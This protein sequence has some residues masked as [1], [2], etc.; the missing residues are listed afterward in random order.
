MKK[1]TKRKDTYCS[2]IY[3][4][5]ENTNY[6]DGEN[7]AVYDEAYEWARLRRAKMGGVHKAAPNFR[8]LGVIPILTVMMVSHSGVF[9]HQKTSANYTRFH[10]YF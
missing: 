7:R 1:H 9:H 3:K 6:S 10:H 2:S 4:G 8:K 5:I